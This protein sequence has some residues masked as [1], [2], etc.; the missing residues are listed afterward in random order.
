[1]ATIP[2]VLASALQYHQAGRLQEAGALYLQILQAEPNHADALH[3]YGVIAHQSGR[4]DVAIRHISQAIACNPLDARFHN[5]IGEAYRAQG[6]LEEAVG[7]YRQALALRPMYAEARL[8]LGTVLKRQGRIAEAVI[9]YEQALSA[10]PSYAEAHSNLGNAFQ[11]MGKVEAAIACYQRA[12]E[13]KPDYV[14]AHSNLGGALKG[15]GK[16][17]EAMACYRRA[18]AMNPGDAAVHSNMLFVMCYSP[19]STVETVATAHREWNDRHARP[20]A[21]QIRPHNND[22]TP[23]RRLRVGYVSAD[24]WGHAVGY[25][26]EPLFANHN[27]TNVMVFA[28]SN[29]VHVDAT[30]KRLQQSTDGWRDIV[31]TSDD[32]LAGLIREDGIDILVDLSGH[33]GGN[34]LP[35]FA[36]K[37]A[38]VQVT[39]IGY[40]TTTGL[41]AMD[42]RLTDQYLSPSDSR[43]WCSEELIRLPGCFSCYRP[44][45][46]APAVAPSPASTTGH[47]TF[48]SFNN[49]A[50]VTPVV[51]GLWA[52]ILRAVPQARLILK[53]AAFADA[54]Q[55]AR[56]QGLFAK[57]DVRGERLEFIPKTA[58]H[59]EHLALYGRVDIG[60]DSFPY[61]GC[62]TTCDALWMGVPVVTLAG[63]MS[64]NR[65]G[66]TLLSNLGVDDLIATTSG[67]YVEKAV[68]LATDR[69][70]LMALRD[71]LRPR[72]AAS[73]L[74][75]AKTLTCEV[76]NAYRSMW[77][78]WCKSGT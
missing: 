48:G 1:M 12:L 34:R 42:Y 4:H 9:E 59:A 20:L 3:L 21:S 47:V 58:T 17:E 66:V 51:V 31:G 5:N 10:N 46:E 6:K 76:E 36:R 57:E 32:A 29:G 35:V 78:R 69:K 64:F 38:P 77:H 16:L 25:F 61:N 41:S 75:D 54:G 26:I 19:A 74:C 62:T 37:P 49:L 13:L 52:E 7:H 23:E 68:K 11:E 67:A 55:V 24:F 56:Y 2:E 72:M 45:G 28:Y 53:D 22:R 40:G 60:L 30:T 65:Y 39:Y 70:R 8:N 14:T 27:R 15:Q 63:A 44:S 73:P 71:E 33:T 43:E 50:K 18:L